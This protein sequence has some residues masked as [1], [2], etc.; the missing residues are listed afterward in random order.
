MFS[1]GVQINDYTETF[2]AHLRMCLLKQTLPVAADILEFMLTHGMVPE[3]IQLQNLI[4][5]L[6]K[7]NNWSRA[8][9]LFK[10]ESDNSA[11]LQNQ[12][13]PLHHLN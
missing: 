10:R 6:G 11:V 3:T 5:R 8:R 9:G 12:Q 2:S 1:D 4:H 13:L 7:Q